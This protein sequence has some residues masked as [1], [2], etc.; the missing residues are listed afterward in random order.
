MVVVD[1]EVIRHT[2]QEGEEAG[3]V[4]LGSPLFRILAAKF[5]LF[6]SIAFCLFCLVFFNLIGN[7]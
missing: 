1:D 6:P 7:S 4:I 5:S 2:N 3:S